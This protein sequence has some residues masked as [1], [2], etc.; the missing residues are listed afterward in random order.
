MVVREWSS[1]CGPAPSIEIGNSLGP[2]HQNLR[3]LVPDAQVDS[4]G[5][6]CGPIAPEHLAA[7]IG[8]SARRAPRLFPEDAAK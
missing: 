3:I 4:R 1:P 8:S 5:L 7:P 2:I 6:R